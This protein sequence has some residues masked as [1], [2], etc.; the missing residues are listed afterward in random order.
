LSVHYRSNLAKYK[1]K[2]GYIM[3]IILNNECINA[4]IDETTDSCS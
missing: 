3:H 1:F 2:K 4:P